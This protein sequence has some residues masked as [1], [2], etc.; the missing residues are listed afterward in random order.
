MAPAIDPATGTLTFRS[1]PGAFGTATIT[2]VLHDD[3]GIANG[4]VDTSAPQSFKITVFAPPTPQPDSFQGWSGSDV[5]GD[6]LA[7]DTDPQGSPLTLQSTP[8]SGPASGTLTLSSSDGTFDY[9]PNAG[10]T[11]TDTFTY[12]VANG[13]GATATAQ[14]TITIAS[15]TGVATSLVDATALEEPLSSL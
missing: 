7:N 6:L 11:G 3:G 14:V 13:Y 1:A 15:S 4:G 9:V 10:F 2:F 12:T 5:V 8:A